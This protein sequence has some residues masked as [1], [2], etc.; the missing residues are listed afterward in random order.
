V[1]N[2]AVALLLLAAFLIASVHL[3]RESLWY[4]EGWSLWAVRD[5]GPPP[6][7]VSQGIQFIRQSLANTFARVRGDVHPPLYFVMLDL[8]VMLAGESVYAVRLLSTFLA[9]LGLAVTYAVGMRLF[10]RKTGLLALVVLGTTSFFVYYAREARMYSLLLALSTLSTWAYLRWLRRPTRWRSVLY[11]LTLT[12][13]LYTHY[14]GA[15][16]ILAHVLHLLARPKRFQIKHLIPYFLALLLFLFWLPTLLEQIRANNG[17]PLAQALPTDWGT[18]AA[19]WLILTSG[20]WGLYAVPF[21]CGDALPQVRRNAS[22]IALLLLWLLLTPIVVLALNAWVTPV[23]Q[24]RYM[25]GILP[26]GALLT[27]YGLRHIG[28]FSGFSSPFT[29]F[30]KD[31]EHGGDLGGCTRRYVPRFLTRPSSLATHYSLLVTFVLWFAYTQ[32]VMYTEFWPDKPRW[33][34]AVAAMIAARQ[35]LEP[36]ITDFLP[37]SVVAYYDRQMGLRRGVTLD[38]SWRDH[39]AEGMRA[40]V[41]KLAAAPSLWAVLRTDI[42]VNWDAVASLTDGRRVGY[43]D[44]VMNVIFYRF[45]VC[46]DA[47]CSDNTNDQNLRLRFGSHLRYEGSIGHQLYART[48]ERFCVPVDLTLTTLQP[49]DS[50]YTVGLYLTVGYNTLRARWD[51]PLGAHKASEPITLA[52]CLDIPADTP[53][54]PHHLRLIV[55]QQDDAVNRL[56]VIEGPAHSNLYWGTEIILANVSVDEA[57]E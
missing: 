30:S 13:L 4:D 49:L 46:A 45:D 31:K 48:G 11:M 6:A 24:L 2:I 15:L 33:N 41:A 47:P 20:H 42:P 29:V 8:W 50:S 23:F 43:R 28:Q 21:M 17:R 55:Y 34:E 32:L 19:L 1:K 12:S 3:Q 26:A 51:M 57:D 56:P 39:S 14:A 18:V 37:Q 35:P 7:S 54:G 22:A 36:A 44:S 52:P 9:L 38:L 25:I 5:T 10:D 53:R 16:I 27:A 40:L